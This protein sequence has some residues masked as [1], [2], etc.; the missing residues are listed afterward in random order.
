MLKPCSRNRLDRGGVPQVATFR[1]AFDVHGDT[2]SGGFPG[3]AAGGVRGLSA[4]GRPVRSHGPRRHARRGRAGRAFER[5][6]GQGDAEEP[7]P[8]GR[9]EKD[10]PRVGEARP[11]RLARRQGGIPDSR[12]RLQVGARRRGGP[13][14]TRIRRLPRRDRRRLQPR[15]RSVRRQP[16]PRPIRKV[17]DTPALESPSTGSSTLSTARSSF[18][19]IPIP[20]RAF[21]ATRRRSAPAT[22]SR[23]SSTAAKPAE[24]TRPICSPDDRPP[25][26]RKPSPSAP[27]RVDMLRCRA[28]S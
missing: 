23:S 16:R 21:T 11:D 14:R 19:P 2:G 25:P 20:R 13:G 28:L 1:G 8:P 5:G 9:P 3:P 17:R 6:A 22:P 4:D 18:T 26:F 7:R 15:G 27:R 12:P 10:D 24:S